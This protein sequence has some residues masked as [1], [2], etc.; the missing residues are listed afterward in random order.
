MYSLETASTGLVSVVHTVL[1]ET[2]QPQLLSSALGPVRQEAP[3]ARG[4]TSSTSRYN[5]LQLRQQ[6][7][8]ASIDKAMWSQL[9]SLSVQIA[10]ATKSATATLLA[11]L[12]WLVAAIIKNPGRAPPGEMNVPSMANA[13]RRRATDPRPPNPGSRLQRCHVLRTP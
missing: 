11:R 10:I 3:V 2:S 6:Y 9:P 1:P 12:L 7:T 13:K 5:V 4:L 8:P